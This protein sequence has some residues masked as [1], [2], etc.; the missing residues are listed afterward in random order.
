MS[1]TKKVSVGLSSPLDRFKEISEFL[2]QLS[3]HSG[4]MQKSII[5]NTIK[6][7]MQFSVKKS[8]FD[9]YNQFLGQTLVDYF[10]NSGPLAIKFGQILASREDILGAEICNYLDSLL[11]Q[12]KAP[13]LK[14]LEKILKGSYPKN[15]F[16]FKTI[17]ERPIGVG[18]IGAVYQAELKDGTQVVVKI[19]RPNVK[20]KIQQDFQ[21][22]QTLLT[23][24]SR[25]FRKNKPILFE[26][27]ERILKDLK[28]NID[29]ETDFSNE[30]KNIIHFEKQLE[31]KENILVPQVYPELSN[32]EIL[33]IE[34]IEG[35]NL[36]T[37]F[38]DHKISE[39]D[40]SLA[41]ELLQE[42]LSQVFVDGHFH[43]DPHMG[44]IMITPEKKLAFIDLG[45]SG[46]FAHKERKLLRQAIKSF[47]KKDVD[48]T[49]NALIKFGVKPTHFD[50]KAFRKDIEKTYREQMERYQGE[51][52]EQ[53]VF[54]LDLLVQELFKVAYAHQLYVPNNTVLLIKSI[55]TIDGVVR[56]IDPHI[57]L[58]HLAAPI[59]MRGWLKELFR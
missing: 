1:S 47:V 44:N 29:K 50:E 15:K 55:V 12:Q 16:P 57:K 51:D 9:L 39:E 34:R 41:R 31:R 28:V 35:Q 10:K 45:L 46:H 59:I 56:K 27:L 36:K 54:R 18:S 6:M 22:F 32:K 11:D 49:F 38:A 8:P 21:F 17:N 53:E 30:L 5:S 19:L 48:G 13:N 26:V 42:I 58:S 24:T 3:L 20:N 14:R 4:R 40:K 7:P 2:W 25:L 23:Y 43:A 37:Y 52:K 33:V